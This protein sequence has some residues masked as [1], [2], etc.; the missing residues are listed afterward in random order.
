MRHSKRMIALLLGSLLLISL[1]FYWGYRTGYACARPWE[2][3]D[4][5]NLDAAQMSWVIEG[6]QE[7]IVDL[8]DRLDRA[9]ETQ[10]QK[11]EAAGDIRRDITDR[12]SAR[13]PPPENQNPGA[14]IAPGFLTTF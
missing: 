3:T 10:R 13:P 2:I 14:E 11:L 9:I 12:A 6:I 4:Y 7:R 8:E 1:V 5:G